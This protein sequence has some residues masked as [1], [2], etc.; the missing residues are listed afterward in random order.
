MGGVFRENTHFC[1]T[2]HG[3][4]CYNRNMQTKSHTIEI[5]PDEL[6]IIGTAIELYLEHE[7]KLSPKSF[8]WMEEDTIQLLRDLT[9]CGYTMYINAGNGLKSGYHTQDVDKWLKDMKKRV[10]K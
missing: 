2:F 5:N 3:Y 4:L 1:V 10:V 6:D 9:S 7:Y 8:E